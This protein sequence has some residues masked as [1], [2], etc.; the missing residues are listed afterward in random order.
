MK[1]SIIV[2]FSSHLTDVENQI[3]IE[4][5]DNTIGVK[6]KAVCYSNFNEFSR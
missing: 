3:F 6:H 2:V 1:N 4:H 5:I